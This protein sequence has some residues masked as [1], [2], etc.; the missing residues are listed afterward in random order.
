MIAVHQLAKNW[1]WVLF[2]GIVAV[3]FGAYVLYLAFTS[4]GMAVGFMV[5]LFAVFAFADGLLVL[6]TGLSFAHPES[7]RWWWMIMQGLA[8]IAAGVLTWFYPAI[9]ALVLGILIAIWAI[10]TGVF[11]IG[12]AVQLRKQ[13]AGEIL[14]LIAGLI[15][16]ALGVVL[17]IFAWGPIVAVLW[18][19][20]LVGLYALIAGISLVALSFR[21]RSLAA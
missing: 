21:L 10:F 19:A 12:A 8:G 11:E 1:G 17:L 18:W 4:P 14:L 3:L 7:G 9:T 15:S 5:L 16:I 6:I 2:R 13:I 20:W